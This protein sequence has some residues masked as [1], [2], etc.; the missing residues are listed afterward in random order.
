VYIHLAGTYEWDERKNRANHTK[1]G[2]TFETASKV[3]LDP[4][5]I[6]VPDRDVGH[7]QRWHTIGF[8]G[9]VLT[10]CILPGEPELMG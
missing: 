7:E 5:A 2:V 3:F 8:V 9:V 4:D 6:Q 10:V 1:H